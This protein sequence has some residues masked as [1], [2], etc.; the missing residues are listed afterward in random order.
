MSWASDE[1][2]MQPPLIAVPIPAPAATEQTNF[3]QGFPVLPPPPTP[4]NSATSAVTI[5][6]IYIKNLHAHTSREDLVRML[7]PW[8][9]GAEIQRPFISNISRGK[10]WA[11]CDVA[12]G[13]AE[14]LIDDFNWF[15]GVTRGE[16]EAE[17]A[18]S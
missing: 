14:R 11:K 17:Y 9:Q 6:K 12:A 7:S 4:A 18:R 16:A 15:T 5:S 13:V 10:R 8:S 2:I 1:T 3:G